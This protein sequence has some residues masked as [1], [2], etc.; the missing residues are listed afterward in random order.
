MAG[1]FDYRFNDFVAIYPVGN[2]HIG[3]PSCDMDRAQTVINKIT[4]NENDYMVGLGDFLDMGLVETEGDV[5]TQT[6]NPGQAI[7][8]VAEMLR[9]LARAGKTLCL[10]DGNHEKRLSRIAGISPMKMI[11][12]MLGIADRYAPSAAILPAFF[13][14]EDRSAFPQSGGGCDNRLAWGFEYNPS[15]GSA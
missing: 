7:I 2:L 13:G 3:S 14:Y 6:K 10:L 11:A 4:K 9:P 15:V 1:C 8:S 12:E 5:Y